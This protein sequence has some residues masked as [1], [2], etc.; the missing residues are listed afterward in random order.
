M[1]VEKDGI[2]T[3]GLKNYE[4]MLKGSSAECADCEVQIFCRYCAA[5][6]FYAGREADSHCEGRRKFLSKM[7]W[8]M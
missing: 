4:Q 6:E 2:N 7:V 3:S 5:A 1:I 8:G